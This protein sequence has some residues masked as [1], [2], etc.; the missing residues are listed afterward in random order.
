[1]VASFPKRDKQL[2]GESNGKLFVVVWF[3]PLHRSPLP[4]E[5]EALHQQVKALYKIGAQLPM[6]PGIRV[7]S[8]S[9]STHSSLEKGD[10]G[11]CITS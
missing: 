11:Q 9:S 6:A 1:M 2:G 10:S 8:S 4:E 5:P 7:D 3:P